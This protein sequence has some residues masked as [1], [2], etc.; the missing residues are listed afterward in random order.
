VNDPGGILQV[1]RSAPSG[2]TTLLDE[3]LATVDEKLGELHRE[4]V[5]LRKDMNT[6]FA[7]LRS[8]MRAGFADLRSE[9]HTAVGSIRAD[10]AADRA[11]VAAMHRQM[12][13]LLGGFMIA[14]IG[15]LAAVVAQL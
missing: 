10:M 12:L 9:M 1:P 15:L 14:L 2:P 5:S 3:R 11:Q 13:A 7:D 8:E 4:V 6:G